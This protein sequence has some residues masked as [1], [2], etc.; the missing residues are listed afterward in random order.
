MTVQYPRSFPSSCSMQ[1]VLL[2][3]SPWHLPTAELAVGEWI[4]A[5]ESRVWPEVVA[6]PGPGP[7]AAARLEERAPIAGVA[8]A[9]D[10]DP[11]CR[12][13]NGWSAAHFVEGG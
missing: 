7:A 13:D 1:P 6:A 9:T 11:R 4:L 12:K 3:R 5:L 10:A 8:I 2:S